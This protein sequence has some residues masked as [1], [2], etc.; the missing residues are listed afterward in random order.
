MKL[1]KFTKSL[2][3]FL[4]I[5]KTEYDNLEVLSSTNKS[6]EIYGYYHQIKFLVK[7]NL[8]WIIKMMRLQK[9]SN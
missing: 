7:Q 5:N 3:E 9:I 2:K 6:N 4:N 8:L 1:I